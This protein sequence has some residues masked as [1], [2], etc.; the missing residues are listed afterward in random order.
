[1]LDLNEPQDALTYIRDWVK[2]GDLQLGTPDVPLRLEVGTDQ[3]YLRVAY[4]LFLFY[5]DGPIP[6][7]RPGEYH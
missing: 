2:R 6:P 1:M 5:D 3:D 4:Q 7:L